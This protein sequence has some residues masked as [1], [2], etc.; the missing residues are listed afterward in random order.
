MRSD[1]ALTSQI[2][3][4]QVNIGFKYDYEYNVILLYK[5]E[6]F[7]IHR[8][9]GTIFTEQN[10]VGRYLAGDLSVW[11]SRWSSSDSP[12]QVCNIVNSGIPGLRFSFCKCTYNGESWVALKLATVQAVN[13]YFIGTYLNISWETIKYYNEHTQEVLNS[14]INSSIEDFSSDILRYDSTYYA[15]LNDI[16]NHV[17]SADKL[18]NP[19]TNPQSWNTQRYSGV[20]TMCSN[21]SDGVSVPSGSPDRYW[22][23]LNVGTGYTQFQVA[24]YGGGTDAAQFSFRRQSDAGGNED[25][26]PWYEMFCGIRKYENLTLPTD[27]SGIQIA[28]AKEVE[29]FK[30]IL[31]DLNKYQDGIGDCHIMTISLSEKYNKTVMVPYYGSPAF[32]YMQLD[33]NDSGL[34]AS[35]SSGSGTFRIKG[36]TIF[37]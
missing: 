2:P 28:T 10:G 27:G 26:T 5:T 6:E 24:T 33:F 23:G 13:I 20:Y 22:S 36:M 1:Y 25:W 17:Q 11:F 16:P 3:V 7:N 29:T 21:T 34:Y 8:I 37:K 35:I 32:I 12:Q 30:W 31:L 19:W 14:E 18:E 4:E 9:N 15:T